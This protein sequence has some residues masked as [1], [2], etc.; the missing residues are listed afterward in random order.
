MT[1]FLEAALTPAECMDFV[2]TDR[3]LQPWLE[4]HGFNLLKPIVRIKNERRNCLVF[5]QEKEVAHG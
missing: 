3:A 5:Q 1:E 4:G 2:L